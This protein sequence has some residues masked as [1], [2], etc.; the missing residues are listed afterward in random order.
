MNSSSAKDSSATRSRR[1]TERK[2]KDAIN[3]LQETG[4]KVSISA[5][6]KEANVTPALIHNTYPDIAERIRGVIGKTTRSQRDATHDALVKEKERNREL[7]AE[8]DGLKKEMA[9]LASVNL[10]LLSKIAVLSEMLN[11]K[12]IPFAHPDHKLK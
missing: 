11:G 5:V 9:K 4:S 8:V 2:L 6:A 12:I 3:R 1:H 10:T 7:R